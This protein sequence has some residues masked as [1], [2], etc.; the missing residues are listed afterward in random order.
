MS[1]SN[2]N[3]P[4][5]HWSAGDVAIDPSVQIGLISADSHIIEPPNCYIDH[6][7]PAYRDRAPHVETGPNGGAVV[8]CDGIGKPIPLGIIAAA[9]IDPKDIRV[10]EARFEDLHRGGWDPK[11]RLADQDRD[12]V[13]AEVIYPSVGMVLCNHP[14][15]GFKRACF[16]AYNRWLETFQSVA[17]DRLYGLGQSAATSVAETIADFEDIKRR[18]LAGVMLPCEPMTEYDYD[19]PRFDPVW[20]AAID[21][22][23]PLSFHI[24]TSS[25][26]SKGIFGSVTRS[27]KM[28]SQCHTVIRANQDVIALLIWGQVFERFPGLKVV[29][30]E[31]DAGWAPHFMY[32]LDH[33]YKRHRYWAKIEPMAQM[34]SAYFRENIYLTFQDD[35]SAFDQVHNMNPNRLCW[36]NDFPHSDSTWPISQAILTEHSAKLDPAIKRRILRDNT[37]ELYG[38]TLAA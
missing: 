33:F 8:V 12:G 26:N 16:T 6:I 15:P 13:V 28:S 3:D 19:D 21:L 30:A 32:R 25:R 5:V 1:G 35:W 22:K 17:P 24:L 4:S 18:G 38:M 29:C 20:Q 31:A 23:L 2:M 27:D 7:D 37:I 14:D 10:D 11:A 9:G 34:P 36:A